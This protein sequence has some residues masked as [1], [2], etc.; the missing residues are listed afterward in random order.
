MT[1]G[2]PRTPKANEKRRR[3]RSESRDRVSKESL[4]SQKPPDTI[5]GDS[6]FTNAGPSTLIVLARA[7]ASSLASL[8]HVAVLPRGR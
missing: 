6:D 3:N 5:D 1:S 7:S 2:T 4:T 8:G